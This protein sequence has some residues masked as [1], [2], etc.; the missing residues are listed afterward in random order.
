MPPVFLEALSRINSKRFYVLLAAGYGIISIDGVDAN[1][2][3]G[4]VAI[5]AL[6]GVASFTMKADKEDAPQYVP[7]MKAP[8][9]GSAVGEGVK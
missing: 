6:A 8:E 5:L 2:R 1:I 9:V 4:L 3:A 7:P